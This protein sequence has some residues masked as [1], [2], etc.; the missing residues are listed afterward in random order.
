MAPVRWPR[1]KSHLPGTVPSKSYFVLLTDENLRTDGRVQMS[2]SDREP[3][4]NLH[5]TLSPSGSK[6]N[7]LIC[8]R[9]FEGT[10][11][12]QKQ[13]WV[14]LTQMCTPTRHESVYELCLSDLGTGPTCSSLFSTFLLFLNS[15]TTTVLL[16]FSESQFISVPFRNLLSWH[17]NLCWFYI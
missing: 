17:S 9:Q 2:H 6:F 8:L 12:Q 1:P 16:C 3:S 7:R 4:A 14:P 11:K 5:L 10:L 15:W 13:K